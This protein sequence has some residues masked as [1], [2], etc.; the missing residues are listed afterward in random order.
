MITNG[1][2][3]SVTDAFTSWNRIKGVDCDMMSADDTDMYYVMYMNAGKPKQVLITFIG[4]VYHIV[5]P[6]C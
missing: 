5:K 4:F 1:C 3:S 2:M 6:F